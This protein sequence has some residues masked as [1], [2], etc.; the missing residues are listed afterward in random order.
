MKSS[1]GRFTREAKLR[2]TI[3][4]RMRFACHLIALCLATFKAGSAQ[5]DYDCSDPD[6]EIN[7]PVMCQYEE[8]FYYK[9]HPRPPRV[10]WNQK[11]SG[12]PNGITPPTDIKLESGGH[13]VGVLEELFPGTGV[14]ITAHHDF[15]GMNP[16]DLQN[17][18][19][20]KNQH[21][22]DFTCYQFYRRGSGVPGDPAGLSELDVIL[23]VPKHSNVL[24]FTPA[25][26]LNGSS[27]LGGEPSS[28]GTTGALYNMSIGDSQKSR[29]AGLIADSINAGNTMASVEYE[30]T[31]SAIASPILQLKMVDRVIAYSPEGR[32]I[33]PVPPERAFYVPAINTFPGGSGSIVYTKASQ[34]HS[35]RA[36]G[37]VE[38]EFR[39]ITFGRAD[40]GAVRVI[41]IH[42]LFQEN[43][44]AEPVSCTAPAVSR[45]R[46]RGQDGCIPKDARGAG[47]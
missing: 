36:A 15:E 17:S 13:F 6:T 39:P 25:P 37:V 11:S 4:S 40:E 34:S 18:F 14:F 42:S 47:N 24:S 7:D 20:D 27:C 33:L 29:F 26:E 1:L 9:L 31:G 28:Q 19:A 45:K 32:G 10:I 41:P 46:T 5:A 12:S 23:T 30:A 43:I 44:F 16:T 3:R 22:N 35:F 2:P 8:S 21:L 38:C